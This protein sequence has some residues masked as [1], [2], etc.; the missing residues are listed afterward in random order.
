MAKEIPILFSTPMVVAID[1]DLKGETRRTNGLKGINKEPDWWECAGIILKKDTLYFQFRN[2]LNSAVVDVRSPYGKPGDLLWVREAFASNV[3]T[4]IQT[5]PVTIYRADFP[6]SITETTA[7]LQEF[8]H[9]WKPSIHMPKA[10]SRFWLENTGITVERL[11]HISEADAKREGVA[12]AKLAGYGDI[13]GQSTF[14]EGF[15]QIWIDIN[16]RASLCENPWVFVI[17][18]REISRNGLPSC[19]TPLLK[20]VH[21][22]GMIDFLK[23]TA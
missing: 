3:T 8:G 23:A 1:N 10:I 12:P 11:H 2:K 18:F 7:T 22:K 13:I 4:D 16:G 17:K 20:P 19:T 14:K 21:E 15:F 5:H 6:D 9:R